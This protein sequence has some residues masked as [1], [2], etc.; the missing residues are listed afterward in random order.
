MQYKRERF[1]VDLHPTDG[2]FKVKQGQEIGKLGNSGGSTGP[3]L[4]FEIRNTA[5]E[6]ALNP[7]LFGLPVSDKTPPEIRDMKVYLLNEKREVLSSKPFP[8]Q[9]RKDGS[10]GVAGDTVSLGTWR[11]GFGVKA[12]DK[13]TGHRNDNGIYGISLYANGQLVYQFRVDELDFDETRYMNAHVDY[14]A[15]KRYGAWFHRCFLLPGDRLSNYSRTETLGSVAL[16]KDK[17]VKIIL[18]VTDAASNT[19]SITFWVKRNENMEVIAGQPYQFE[20]PWD[21]D[22]RID[23]EDFSMTLPKGALYE[24]LPF[25]YKTTPD[26]SSGVYS[27]MH[28][29]HDTRTPVHRYFEVSIRPHNLPLEL[30]PKA[31]IANCGD[32][33]P[34]NCG[35]AW[36]G[37]YLVARVRQFGDY[38]VMADTDAPTITPVVFDSDMR[39]KSTMSFR[40]RDNFAVSGDADY[41]SYR[42]TVDGQWVLFEYDRKRDRLT[43]TFDGRVGAGEHLLRLSVKDDRGNEALFERKFVR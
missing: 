12:F 15:R 13:Q 11:I 24:T 9:H 42:G 2:Q 37:D 6:R 41:L 17:P 40:V 27:S 38:C 43:H 35:G 39:R 29:L 34:D 28:H 8:V 26:E 36:R 30:R 7:L 14:A 18:K 23:L 16:S 31:V 32:G 10:V 25:Q 33:R 19:S 4:H 21:A 20:L 22:S 5:T 1:E 3:H